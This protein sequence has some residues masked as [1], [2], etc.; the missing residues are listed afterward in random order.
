MKAVFIDKLQ[1]IAEYYEKQKR[2]HSAI[3]V[4]NSILA[5]DP[6][7]RQSEEAIRRISSAPDPSLADSARP[8]DL[9]ADV[10]D[11][12]IRR[13]NTQHAE[14]GKKAKLK[15]ENYTTCTNAGYEVVVRC[16]EAM[17]QVN[18]FFRV[19]LDYGTPTNDRS[20]PHIQLHIYKNKDEY[21]K[22]SGGQ[23]W[24]RGYHRAG[25]A[26]VTYVGD[27]G[28]EGMVRTL[29]HE[30]GYQFVHI[31]TNAYGT[32]WL[33]EGLATYFEGCRLL[34]NGTV[35]FIIS[36]NHY[37]FDLTSRLANGWMADHQD[38][39][40]RSDPRTIPRA[41]LIWKR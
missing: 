17:E 12:W 40:D 28:F 26:V 22:L 7:N 3:R 41:H 39:V 1:P 15:R 37:L 14:S 8:H 13:F 20:V 27:D 31:A 19:F 29:F 34:N 24:S 10:S 6:L 36:A 11:A 23:E 25:N 35:Q 32:T 2:P 21:H 33:N 9:L 30:A 5:L 18:A 16:A 4:H 38:G